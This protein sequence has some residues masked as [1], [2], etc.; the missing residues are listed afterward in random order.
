LTI[1]IIIFFVDY[2]NS[3]EN[4]VWT[5]SHK[6]G[7]PRQSVHAQKTDVKVINY[8][9][10]ISGTPFLPPQLDFFNYSESGSLQSFPNT[11][12]NSSDASCP[13][14]PELN[15]SETCSPPACG[16]NL[17]KSAQY[18]TRKSNPSTRKRSLDSK[19]KF[20]LSKV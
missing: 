3:S 18:R 8:I 2:H 4:S 12:Q 11:P 7:D 10:T 20:K 14:T 5:L 9:N 1:E 15:G 17:F 6:S 13:A 19:D 16:S